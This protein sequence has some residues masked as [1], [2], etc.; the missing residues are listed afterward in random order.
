MGLRIDRTYLQG[1]WLPHRMVPE[2]SDPEMKSVYGVHHLCSIRS[3][4]IPLTS[5]TK[6]SSQKGYGDRTVLKVGQTYRRGEWIA[7]R[8]RYQKFVIPR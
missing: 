2:V 7:Y 3:S 8:E 5:S 4:N 6:V 1:G